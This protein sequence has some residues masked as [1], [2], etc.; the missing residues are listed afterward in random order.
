[1]GANYYIIS[2]S[3]VI[4]QFKD[5]PYLERLPHPWLK[6]ANLETGSEARLQKY[7]YVFISRTKETHK[8]S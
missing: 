7:V 3:M 8:E 2:T 5:V 6:L 4:I 1:M